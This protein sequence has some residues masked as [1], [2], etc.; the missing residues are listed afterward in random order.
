MEEKANV[1]VVLDGSLHSNKRQTIVMEIGSNKKLL[2]FIIII[3][4]I[5][6]ITDSFFRG[7]LDTL[8]IVRMS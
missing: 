8:N 2:P 7:S 6:I 5:L 3:I 4:I 1:V